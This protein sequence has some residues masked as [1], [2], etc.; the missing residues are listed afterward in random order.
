MRLLSIASVEMPSGPPRLPL[1]AEV[2][3]QRTALGGK[4]GE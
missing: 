1:D 4:R 3:V 2:G